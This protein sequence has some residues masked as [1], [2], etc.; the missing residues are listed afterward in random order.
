EKL[1]DLVKRAGGLKKGAY[2][3]G[4]FLLRKTFE[5]LTNNDTIILKNKLATLKSS[6]TDTAK[7]KT[8]DNTLKDDMKIVGIRLNEVLD[9]DESIF[10]ILLQD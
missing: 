4:A 2:A 6:F 8:A 1:S 5:D 3:E 10:D 7:A 9:N